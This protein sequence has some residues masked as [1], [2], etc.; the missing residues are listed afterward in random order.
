MLRMCRWRVLACDD[1]G[2][3]SVGRAPGCGPGCRG[4]KSHRPPQY[5]CG[6]PGL[7]AGGAPA[8][9][10]GADLGLATS[11]LLGVSTRRVER[12]AETLGIISLSKSQVSDLAKSL[13]G[14]VEQF[15]SR[16]LD[17]MLKLGLVIHSVYNGYW[18]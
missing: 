10:A 6:F 17:A 7:A 1:G 13:D 12:L 15:R 9:G 16:P 2:R 5:L 8:S 14:A 4:F 11:Y 18:F 3:S